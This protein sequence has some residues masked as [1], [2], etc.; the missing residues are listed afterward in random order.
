MPARLRPDAVSIRSAPVLAAD[1]NPV[2]HQK[3]DPKTKKS[4]FIT[5]HGPTH[6]SNR[7]G[8][9][10]VVPLRVDRRGVLGS[11]GLEPRGVVGV[12]Q[13][14]RGLGNDARAVEHVAVVEEGL[15]NNKRTAATVQHK[16]WKRGAG[17]SQA[18]AG[19]MSRLYRSFFVQLV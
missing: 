2:N 7:S 11:L 12:T 17:V 6:R 19:C 16:W 8:K 10:H 18:S 15:E 5:K 4:A 3:N 14:A 1:Q 9:T 13:D